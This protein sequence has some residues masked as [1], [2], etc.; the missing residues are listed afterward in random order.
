[1]PT[2]SVF[3]PE[4]ETALLKVDTP[5]AV[6]AVTDAAAPVSVPTIVTGPP[7]LAA[8]VPVAKVFAPLT[9]TALLSV[10]DP[11]A[12]KAWPTVTALAVV[13]P[14]TVRLPATV[15]NPVPVV[16][17]DAPDN[18]VF[19]SVL[20]PETVNVDAVVLPNVVVPALNV[21]VT[22]AEFSVA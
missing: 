5:L 2:V 11:L 9:L 8:P 22:T 4:M 21:F 7:K 18:K 12:T 20:D 13:A 6:N 1:M 19:P 16:R 3:A 17:L 10:T 15:V 14:A